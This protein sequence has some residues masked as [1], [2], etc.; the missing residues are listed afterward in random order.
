MLEKFIMLLPVGYRPVRL[1]Y[2]N[3]RVKFWNV[4]VGGAPCSS[5]ANVQLFNLWSQLSELH[6]LEGAH[7]SGDSDR[8]D[9]SHCKTVT[10][11]RRIEKYF[12][13]NDRNTTMHQAKL[14]GLNAGVR[15]EHP[16]T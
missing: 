10:D 3:P 6:V 9:R 16:D 8:L 11:P 5:V 4:G 2:L 1:N 14:T 13:K 15:V 7:R 12:C